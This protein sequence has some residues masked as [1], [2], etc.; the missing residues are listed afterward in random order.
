M[1]RQELYQALSSLPPELQIALAV[2]TAFVVGFLIWSAQ[3]VR[4]RI[5]P[6]RWSAMPSK[7]RIFGVWPVMTTKERALFVLAGLGFLLWGYFV[8]SLLRGF[9][10]DSG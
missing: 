10:P 9:A 5:G 7:L 4:R 1:T 6:A 2:G 8:Y 3:R